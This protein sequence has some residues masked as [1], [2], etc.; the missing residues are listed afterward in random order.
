MAPLD[1]LTATQKKR[2]KLFGA[3]VLAIVCTAGSQL[4]LWLLK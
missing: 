2:N 4:V 3:I 1:P